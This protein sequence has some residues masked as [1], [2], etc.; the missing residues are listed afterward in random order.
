[1]H[2]KKLGNIGES[3][4]AKYLLENGFVIIKQNFYSRFGEI[5][6]IARD[7]AD[8]IF[9]EVKTRKNFLCGNPSESVNYQKQLKI[10]NAALDFI[11]QNDIVNTN[12]R[13][14]VIEIILTDSFKV[15][16]I[17]NAFEL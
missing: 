15:N 3:I 10:K 4:A 16:H 8:I 2:K 9:I 13:F 5:D 12:F 11:A 7:D 17:V 6:I 1:M 14:D